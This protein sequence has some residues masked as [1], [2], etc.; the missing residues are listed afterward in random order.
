M[1]MNAC[2]Y[3]GPIGR[4]ILEE[5]NGYL[6][7][8]WLGDNLTSVSSEML[9]EETPLLKEAHLQLEAYF[10]R[11]LKQF[12][13]PLSPMEKPLLMVKKLVLSAIHGQRVL[14]VGPMDAIRCLFLF[15]VIE[16]WVLVVN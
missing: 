12:D 16:W 10:A 6:T 2:F 4:Y 3:E 5:R 14:L 13:L 15:H 7:H 1:G 11:Q 8:L 9:T